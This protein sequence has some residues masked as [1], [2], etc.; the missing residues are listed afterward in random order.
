MKK[1]KI[2]LSPYEIMT[3]L[4]ATQ[5]KVSDQLK[6][7]LDAEAAKPEYEGLES[8]IAAARA[9]NALI[10]NN[11]EAF[12]QNNRDDMAFL[13]LAP[14]TY[15]EQG[16]RISVQEI[17]EQADL[18]SLQISHV[19][20]GDHMA[21]EV[22]AGN[23]AEDLSCEIRFEKETPTEAPEFVVPVVQRF[24]SDPA[25]QSLEQRIALL[26][27]KVL[28][29]SDFAVSFGYFMD[30]TERDPRFCQKG[31]RVKKAPNLKLALERLASEIFL[32]E[33]PRVTAME[34]YHLK[35]HAFLHGVALL[36]G[37]MANY[38]F[39]QDLNYGMTAV[40]L[41]FD[42]VIFSRLTIANKR[43]PG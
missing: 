5:P 27:A 4:G 29:E 39:F 20:Q 35:R 16:R 28:D 38:F 32:R 17:M 31:K 33:K 34:F 19:D 9:V 7:A 2:K 37:R 13:H 11:P 12:D 23:E 41:D 26:K 6:Q 36:N 10:K 22:K 42:E 25:D 15:D 21:M 43:K 18:G 3:L 30:E 24:H 40:Q 14:F 8:K 1:E